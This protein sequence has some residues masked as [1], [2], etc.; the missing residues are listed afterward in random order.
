MMNNAAV[1]SEMHPQFLDK[2][3]D[4]FDRVLRINLLG[5]MLGTQRAARHMAGH[6]GGAIVNVSATSA[7]PPA[8][9]SP[10]TARRRLR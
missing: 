3:F 4:D 8:S 10:A 9:A 2:T 6:G 1:S 5:V 7:S